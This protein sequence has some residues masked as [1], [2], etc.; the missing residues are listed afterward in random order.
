MNTMDITY[1]NISAY[2]IPNIL[3]ISRII[4]SCG[5]D[6]YQRYGLSHWNNSLFKTFLIVYYT[7]LI[8]HTTLWAIYNNET[9]IATFQTKREGDYLNFC[10]FAVDPRQAGQGVGSRCLG[11]MEEIAGEIGLRG[12]TCEVFDKST[13]ALY[14]YLNRGFVKNGSIST[15]KYTELKLVKRI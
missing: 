4:C 9:I 12:L 6:M 1:H 2:S 14:F 11:I 15:M 5:E 7:I 3:K 13:H 10:K 8:K